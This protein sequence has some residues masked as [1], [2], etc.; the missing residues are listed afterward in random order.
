MFGA[1]LI[2]RFK[3]LSAMLAAV[4]ILQG[5]FVLYNSGSTNTSI[6]EMAERHLPNLND[7]HELKYSVAQVQQ[8]LQDI[9]ATRGF[10]GLD[11]GF[12]TAE[13]YAQ[14]F[15]TIAERLARNDPEHAKSYRD[16]VPVFEAFY[17]TG[18]EMAE[19]YVE[20]GP[21]GG[22]PL[23]SGFDEVAEAMTTEVEAMLNRIINTAR[24]TAK[25]QE[26]LSSSTVLSVVIGSVLVLVGVVILFVSITS[27]LRFL[28]SLI[29]EMD[30][31]ASGD[32]TSKIDT[33]RE[34]EFGQLASSMNAMQQKL[35]GMIS[36]IMD[37]TNQLSATSEEMSATMTESSQNIRTQQNET[38]QM[39]TAM[40]Q[41]SQSVM[42]VARNVAETA[43]AVNSTRSE[44][45]HGKQV[46]DQTLQGI[47]NLS[48]QIDSTANVITKV[49][50]DSENIS[51]VLDVIKSI[52]EQTNLLALNAA[53]EAAR[54]G[55]QGRGFAVV[56]DEVRTLAG[57][58]QDSTQEINAIIEQLQ[59]GARQAAQ[60][61]DDS[62][63]QTNS[64]VDQATQAGES[65]GVIA[66]SITQIDSMSSMIAA[67][68][69]EQN[70]VAENMQSS[71]SQINQSI[72]G[73][74]TS[75]EQTA[76]AANELAKM[77]TTLQGMMQQFRVR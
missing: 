74:A 45:E 4:I 46:V 39:A 14:R 24:E 27:S 36:K 42:E 62:R 61:M 72:H 6:E 7:A 68:T 33:D 67:A 26:S 77:A 29:D 56:A 20:M 73:S 60:S 16:M 71:V 52:A 31:I 30:K 13:E 41:M 8:W 32:L 76:V 1:T 53:I 3:V 70:A 55:E 38:D 65:L 54:A 9:A 50:Q 44:T 47:R 28:P 21:A 5:A 15:Y 66:D 19:A 75:A 58:T 37:M 23:M 64:V 40:M 35:Q 43:N 57:R 2:T 69:E 25:T 11:D 12:D 17:S 48:Q 51:T 22:N 59:S 63:E 34:D 49:G 18:K 10:D